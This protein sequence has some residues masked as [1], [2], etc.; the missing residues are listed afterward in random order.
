MKVIQLP[1]I[2]PVCKYVTWMVSL[3]NNTTT[4][5][6]SKKRALG[7]VAKEKLAGR[8]PVL[9]RCWTC[10]SGANFDKD[11]EFQSCKNPSREMGA[12]S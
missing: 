9:Y 8:D 2:N 3:I 1:K 5:P 4:N 12:Y 6:M 7:I 10:I 11:Y